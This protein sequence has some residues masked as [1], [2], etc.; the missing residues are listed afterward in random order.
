M[1]LANKVAMGT[2]DRYT[3]TRISIVIEISICAGNTEN[4]VTI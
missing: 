1:C 3:G 2:Y 4:E